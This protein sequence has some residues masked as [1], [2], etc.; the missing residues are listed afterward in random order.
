MATSRSVT[1][2]ISSSVILLAILSLSSHALAQTEQRTGRS[3]YSVGEVR[4]GTYYNG[5]FG[6]AIAV[7]LNRLEPIGPTDGNGQV[8]AGS[9]GELRVFGSATLA[10]GSLSEA[11][12]ALSQST[13]EREVTYKVERDD[14]FV[15]SGFDGDTVFYT[16]VMVH[17]DNG[18]FLTFT[19][20][21]DRSLKPVF[22]PITEEVSYSFR[23][24]EGVGSSDAAF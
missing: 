17:P 8:F 4:Y 7:P 9:E 1:F 15:V 12:R 2:Y 24:L 23:A 10:E 11:Y 5:R 14:W 19:L 13:P 22:D 3:V 20:R 18:A 6:Y 16:K 21:Y